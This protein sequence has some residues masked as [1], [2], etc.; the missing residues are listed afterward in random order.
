MFVCVHMFINIIL[1]KMGCLLYLCVNIITHNNI[2]SNNSSYIF[3][4][5]VE[6]L[7]AL[8]LLWLFCDFCLL[9][10]YWMFRLFIFY[11]P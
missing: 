3:A 10:H 11:R 5:R 7:H 9:L 8:S 2:H 1:L 4:S 6:L